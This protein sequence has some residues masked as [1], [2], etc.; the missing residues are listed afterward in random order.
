VKDIRR[1]CIGIVFDDGAF[2][3]SKNK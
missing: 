1:L 2:Q 3:L